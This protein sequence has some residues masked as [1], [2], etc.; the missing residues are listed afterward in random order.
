MSAQVNGRRAG[1]ACGPGPGWWCRAG[2]G[3]PP[4]GAPRGRSGPPP[5]SGRRRRGRGRR[6]ARRP[7]GRAA[8][9]RCGVAYR[10]SAAATAASSDTV[11]QG[12]RQAHPADEQPDQGRAPEQAGV[13][14]RRGQRHALR[15]AERPGAGDRPAGRRWPGRARPARTR[16][17]PPRSPGRARPRACRR[18]RAPSR[19]PARAW[20]RSDRTSRPSREPPTR[21]GQRERRVAR[22][23]DGRARRQGLAQVQGAPVGDRALAVRRAAGDEAEHDEQPLGR[24]RR[25]LPRGCPGVV[26]A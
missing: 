12:G 20:P 7:P 15:A 14:D 23:R 13:P 16:R 9:A 22:C 24:G 21:H 5:G 18:R 25:R 26:V 8:A 10:L 19:G 1:S 11:V 6:R 17:G 2:R 4:S 3:R